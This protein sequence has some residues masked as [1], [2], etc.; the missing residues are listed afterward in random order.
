MNPSCAVFS[1]WSNPSQRGGWWTVV[2][3]SDFCCKFLQI[4]FSFGMILMLL[5]GLTAAHL[6]CLGS[7]G[8]SSYQQSVWGSQ[9]CSAGTCQWREAHLVGQAG[10]GLH[11]SAV[12]GLQGQGWPGL[13][14]YE[15]APGWS[16]TSTC[17]TYTARLL[18]S[19]LFFWHLNF[20]NFVNVWIDDAVH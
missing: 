14:D 3:G 15:K 4:S 19:L 12:G 18:F 11:C 5:N 8:C 10:R 7:N 1:G 13:T 17:Y 6:D 16:F 20:L 2:S 9:L